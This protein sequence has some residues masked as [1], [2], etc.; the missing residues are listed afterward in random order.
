VGEQQGRAVLFR[1][2]GVISERSVEAVIV[3]TT[4]MEKAIAHPTDARLYEQVS[5]AAGNPAT[6][7]AQ[8][9]ATLV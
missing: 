5:M 8:I 9:P 2:R 4:V 7:A 1:A 6:M 3:D